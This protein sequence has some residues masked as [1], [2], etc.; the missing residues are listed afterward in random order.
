MKSM[1]KNLLVGAATIAIASTPLVASAQDWHRDHGRNDHQRMAHHE[2]YHRPVY[3]PAYHRYN[4][5]YYGRAPGGF[6]GYYHNG[7]WY[8]HRRQQAGIWI[9]F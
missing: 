3:R 9:Y 2:V 8:H 1:L 6:Q 7:G 5:G 4:E